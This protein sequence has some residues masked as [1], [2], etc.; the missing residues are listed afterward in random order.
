[1]N[2]YTKEKPPTRGTAKLIWDAMIKRGFDLID[3]HYNQNIWGSVGRDGNY[4]TW[5]WAESQ[6]S[7]GFCGIKN[8]KI[9]VRGM[10]GSSASFVIGE[11][12]TVKLNRLFKGHHTAKFYGH[13]FDI[14]QNE[15]RDSTWFGEWIISTDS[16]KSY[17]DPMPTL[18]RCR[19]ALQDMYDFPDKY[20][21]PDCVFEAP[22]GKA[23]NAR[24]ISKIQ[25][26][27]GRLIYTVEHHSAQGMIRTETGRIWPI[28][29]RK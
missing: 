16:G 15:E 11:T 3:L 23:I 13:T 14:V 20:W 6:S 4:G 10:H 19:A 5:A 7:M 25:G 29:D 28:G 24:L 2:F 1:M 8:G 17:S 18:R 27:N 9:Y 12:P 22:N 21:P 26:D